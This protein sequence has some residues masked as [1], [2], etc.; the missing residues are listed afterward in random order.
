MPAVSKLFLL[1]QRIRALGEKAVELNNRLKEKLA[2]YRDRKPSAEA[3]TKTPEEEY[4]E[5][6]EKIRDK[7]KKNLH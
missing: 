7:R 1:N 5:F 4:R 3:K 6:I 2:A